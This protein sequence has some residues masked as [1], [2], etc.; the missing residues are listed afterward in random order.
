MERIA[1]DSVAKGLVKAVVGNP[2]ESSNGSFIWN[3]MAVQGHSAHL[4]AASVPKLTCPPRPP[5]CA[6]SLLRLVL[7]GLRGKES[8]RSI[9]STLSNKGISE[10]VAESTVSLGKL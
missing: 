7:V 9:I 3:S 2:A 6:P 4:P 8:L 10:A 5:K 1:G